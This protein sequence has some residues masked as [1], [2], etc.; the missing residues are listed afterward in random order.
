METIKNLICEIIKYLENNQLNKG[1]KEI[2][3]YL[4]NIPLESKN[5]NELDSNNPPKKNALLKALETINN[6]SLIS[7]KETINFSL[8][9][10]RWN[11][12]NGLYYDKD[13]DIGN[14]YLC[15]NMNTELIGPVNG[16]FKSKE[17]KLGLFLLEPKIFYKDHKHEAPELYI[18]LTSGTKWRFNDS[19]WKSKSAGSIIYN[20]PYKVHAMKVGKQPFLSVWCWPKNSSKKCT[21]VPKNDWFELE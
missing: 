8:E 14:D 13:C 17:L 18:N 3:N 15:G 11:I 2:T 5:F 20:E 1:D 16:H 21:L 9:S 10:L 7:I 19:D 12:D 6:P 4:K